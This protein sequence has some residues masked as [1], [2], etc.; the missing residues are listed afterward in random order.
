MVDFAELLLS[1]RA[2]LA[3]VRTTAAG[4][5]WPVPATAALVLVPAARA[6]DLF[7]RLDPSALPI[8]HSEVEPAPR[9]GTR[10]RC[11]ICRLELTL[12]PATNRLTVT[13]MDAGQEDKPSKP[14]RP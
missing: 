3:A 11:H 7:A 4:A 6:H 8:R 2:D 10:Y 12:D 5:G 1:E 9:P 13:P 14:R